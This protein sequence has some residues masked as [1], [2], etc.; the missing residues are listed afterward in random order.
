MI[1]DELQQLHQMEMMMMM[2][3]QDVGE[4]MTRV[5]MTKTMMMVR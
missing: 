5:Q 4:M 2:T 3:Q 1:P